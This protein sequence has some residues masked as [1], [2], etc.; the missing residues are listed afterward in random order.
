M[1][2]KEE[3]QIQYDAVYVKSALK[4]NAQITSAHKIFQ[5]LHAKKQ[6]ISE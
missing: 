4:E 3:K 6:S 1:C 5:K 2:N